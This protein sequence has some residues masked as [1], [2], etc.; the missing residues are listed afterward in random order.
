MKECKVK[1]ETTASE[2]QV[3]SKDEKRLTEVSSQDEKQEEKASMLCFKRRKKAAKAAKPKAGSKAADVARKPTPEAGASDHLP[4]PGGAWASIKHLVTRKKR[5]DSKQQQSLEA[6]TQPEI[7]AE[8]TDLSKKKAKSRCKIPCI[9]FSKGEKRSDHSKIIE[10]SDYSI[11][12]QGEAESL[13]TKT[14]TQSDDQATKTKLTQ[15]LIN[16]VV[17]Q[18][19]DDEVCESNV[20]NSIT[21]GENVI[22]VELGIDMVPSGIQTGTVVLEEEIKTI[23]EKQNV[24]PSPAIQTGTVVL[25]EE[26]KTIEEK[27][28]VQPSSAIQTGT[29]VL[30]EEIKTIEEKQN[31][32]PSSA[33]QT[34]TVVLEEEIE[35]I[36]EKQN[37]QPSSA[38]QTGTVVLEEEIETIEEK[39]IVQPSSAIQTGTVVLEEEIETIEEKQNV[40]LSSAIQPGTVVLKEEIKTIEEKQ[41][42]QPSSAIQTGTVVLEEQIKTTEEKQSVQPPSATQTGN[43]VL[44]EEIKT[45]EEK[46]SVHTSSAI[47]IGTVVLEE[48]VKTV[49]KQSVQPQQASPP[50]TSAAEHQPPV[51]SDVPPSPVVVPDQQI[52]EEDKS[53]ITESGLNCEDHESRKIVTEE[54]KPKDTELSQETDFK[55]NEINAEKPKP[56]ESK[57]MEPIAIIITDTEISEFDVK[58][59]KNVPKQFLISIENEQVGVFANDSGFEGRTSEQYETLLIETASSLVKN[60]IQ[61]SV[62]QLVNEMVSDD[63]KIN[64]L[65]Q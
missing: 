42:V 46:Q 23:E 16:E 61:L 13:D 5:S 20:S 47:Q 41:N 48:E 9:K 21:S 3:E 59:S 52:V 53:S 43:V 30:E 25:E 34:G 54:S 19:D 31:V 51:A 1:M 64:N 50:E 32:Q 36:E 60:A 10:D 24:Q 57:R 7:N 6:K 12:V 56:E 28:N 39:Q 35:T 49:E 38:I 26:I 27:Q 37:V 22:S 18:K 65:L 40:Q 2:I 17:S 11:K 8:D 4:P 45:V 29:V 58:K 62:E 63:N 44:E 33:I 15:P 14:P 55:E